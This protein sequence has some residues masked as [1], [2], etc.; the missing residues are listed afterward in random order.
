MRIAVRV[1]ACLLG[2][3]LSL[4]ACAAA[5]MPPLKI[6]DVDRGITALATSLEILEDSSGVRTLQDV[7]RAQGDTPDGFRPAT[8]ERLSRGFSTSSFW[9]RLS[10]DND[11]DDVRSARLVLN[12]TWLQHVDF[13]LLRHRDGQAVWTHEQAGVSDPMDATHR[14]DR[15]PQLAID[16]Q[17]RESVQVL[18][19][20]KSATQSKLNPELHTAEQWHRLERNHALMCGLLIGGLLVLC[21]YSISLWWI[22][23]TPMLA[24]QVAGFALLALYEATYSGYARIALWPES[25]SWSYR[26][27]GVTAT[28]AVLCLMLYFHERY[29]KS[30]VRVPG[31]PFLA[32]LVAIEVIV[33][34]GTLLGPYATFAPIG[35]VNAPLIMLTLTLCAWLHQ[36]R[37][38]PGERPA[39][40]VMLVICAGGLLRIAALTIT[41]PSMSGLDLYALALPGML[42]GMFVITSWSYQQ[43]R[44]RTE[45]LR[46]LAQW[47]DQA[48]RR[49]EQEVHRKT[50]ALSEALDQAEQRTREQKELM[51]YVSHDLRAPMSAIIGN[52][53]LMRSTPGDPDGRL[54]A[55]ERSAAYQLEL[56]DDLVNYA[57]DELGPLS[58]EEQPVH[59]RT[60][61]DDIAQYAEVLARRRQNTFE[62]MIDGALPEAVRLDSKRVQQVLLNLLSNAAKFTRDGRIGLRLEAQPAG[63][64]WRL[65]FEVTDSGPGIDEEQLARMERALAGNEP[66][67]QGGLG[68][69]IA[70]RI[71]RSMDGRLTIRSGTNAGG[72][73]RVGFSLTAGEVLSPLPPSLSPPAASEAVPPRAGRRAR[74]LPAIAPLSP[75]QKEELEALARDG[76]WSDLH[77]WANRMATEERHEALAQAVRQA[78]DRLDFEHIRLIA[79]AAPARTPPRFTSTT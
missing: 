17:P 1:G 74:Q 33:L 21:I 9:L 19:R 18:V 4:W 16:L 62:L 34:L 63:G 41:P 3:A 50:H 76:R 71:V 77:D 15:V 25:T 56:I 47:Q 70:Q 13:H 54:A 57:K 64:S 27:H 28:G 49:L 35:I 12:V 55:I 44:Q 53:R 46:T 58:L 79:R 72:G 51:A 43:S 60:L 20:V 30:P 11:S 45:A 5:G 10:V 7:V 6:S 23:R 67:P 48:Q 22:S 40:V 24:F 78:L 42:L 66:G 52:L 32:A 36:R 61:V 39:M 29:R 69:V 65:H 59:L 8:P 31:R 14:H 26:A 38:G 75:Q 73:T 2:L 37:A 68:L